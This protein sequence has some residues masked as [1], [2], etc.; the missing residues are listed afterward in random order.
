[1]K[2]PAER[3]VAASKAWPWI[4]D[5]AVT[6]ETDDYL[7]VRFPD[8]FGHPLVL[9]RFTPAGPVPD[10][11]EAALAR[12][13]GYGLPRLWWMVRLDSPPGV[14][15]LL[16]GRGATVDATLDV[17][18]RD[19]GYGVPELPPPAVSAELRWATDP[20]TVRD[21]QELGTKVFGGPAAPDDHIASEARRAEKDVPAGAG[22]TVVAYAGG[23]PVACGGVIVAADGV[24][25]LW[26]GAVAEQARGRGLYRAVLSARL[27]YAVRHG[28]TMALVKGRIET[29]GPV[30]RR[31]GFEAYGQ[32]RIYAVPLG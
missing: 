28:A 10:A 3:V 31:A 16:E 9:T 30:L 20:A 1:M 7:I 27:E 12:A 17:L 19:I 18:A 25:L 21:G 29:S 11:V 32:E 8:Y 24:A 26:R 4:P 2:L 5:T 6:A 13:R 14:P 22:G 23:T 15:E